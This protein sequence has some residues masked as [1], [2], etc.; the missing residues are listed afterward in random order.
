[1]ESKEEMQCLSAF[2]LRL[3][4]AGLCKYKILSFKVKLEV[5]LLNDLGLK[6]EIS[7]QAF[8]CLTRKTNLPL[9]GRKCS[10]TDI[11]LLV[12]HGI[13]REKAQSWWES[14]RSPATCKCLFLVLLFAWLPGSE[15]GC[16]QRARTGGG[17]QG[18]WK[19]A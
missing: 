6:R 2:A 12:C 10:R 18:A 19:I 15:W 7:F 8:L 16:T 11:L 1:M 5:E 14:Q 4:T 13:P 17:G 3:G 9:T